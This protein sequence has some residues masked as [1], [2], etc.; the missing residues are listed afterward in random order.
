[1]IYTY[2]LLVATLKNKKFNIKL[3]VLPNRLLKVGLD[4][5]VRTFIIK[6]SELVREHKLNEYKP[7]NIY[8]QLNKYAIIINKSYKKIIVGE[9]IWQYLLKTTQ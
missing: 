7:K 6:D 8:K 3:V 5:P 2:Q 1:M 9:I 4:C